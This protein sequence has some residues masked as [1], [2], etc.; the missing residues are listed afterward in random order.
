MN[1]KTAK[2][3]VVILTVIT[4]GFVAACTN[5]AGPHDDGLASISALDDQQTGLIGDCVLG[6][7]HDERGDPIPDAIVRLQGTTLYTVTN[8]TGHFELCQVPAEGILRLTAYAEGFFIKEAD[9]QV[10]DQDVIVILEEHGHVDNKGY[11][12]LSAGEIGSDTN[13][14]CAKC[15]A[16]PATEAAAGISLPFDEWSRDAHAG[17]ATNPRFLSMFNGTDLLGNQSPLTRFTIQR[18][19]GTIPLPPNLSVPYFGPG[20]VLDFPGSTGNCATCHTPVLAIDHPF[21]ANPNDAADVA[22]EGVT[23][24]FCHKVWDVYLD[25]STGLPYSNMNGVLSYEFLRPSEGH[26]FFAG[27]FDDVA[28]GEDTYSALQNE[29]QFCAPCHFGRFWDVPIYNSFGEW[30]ESAYA[31]QSSE[32]FKT[33]QD[34]HMPNLG[35]DHF[36]TFEAG[37]LVRDPDQIFSHRM[38][39]AADQDLLENAV[40][41]NVSAERIEDVV[42]VSVSIVNDNTGHHIPTDSPLRHLILTV[43]A[44]KSSGAALNLVSGPVLPEWTGVGDP[45]EGYLSGLPG[46]AYAKILRQLW[47]ETMPTGAY[48]TQTDIVSDNR[49]AAFETASSNYR[50][51]ATTDTPVEITV[52]LVL[53]RAF[54]ELMDQ[55]GW[56]FPDVVLS[57]Q[58]LILE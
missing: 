21:D 58:I 32:T 44:E 25:P 50:F 30:L 9:V 18:E 33:C 56:D 27:P 43:T 34:C 47:T 12:F 41:L 15:H 39:G 22:L 57:E 54:I 26:Q 6:I 14:G 31:D 49:I 28:P 5:I 7:V 11:A 42:E 29:S 46:V 3:A 36:A 40:T 53:R 37:A 48:W 20:Y 23:C 1:L 55:K 35:M 8:D 2:F 4:A 51:S 10:G 24:D 16:A 17:S 13:S 19:Y 52:R 45:A 38:P